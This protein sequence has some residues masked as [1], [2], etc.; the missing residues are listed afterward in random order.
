[1]LGPHLAHGQ[2]GNDDD[3]AASR[4]EG[5]PGTA[6]AAIVET[7]FDRA[8]AAAIDDELAAIRASSRG[9]SDSVFFIDIFG[10]LMPIPDRFVPFARSPGEFHSRSVF[11]DPVESLFSLSGSIGIGPIDAG[12]E[13]PVSPPD[14]FEP[15]SESTLSQYGLT[16]VVWEFER[17]SQVHIQDERE[18]IV[19]TDNNKQLWRAMLDAW[20]ELPR[21]P[22]AQQKRGER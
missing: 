7:N 14:G 12:S 9:E 6:I 4:T 19:I 13:S 16:V 20:N 17:F 10:G 11:G 15:C 5:E 21:D 2:C 1:M 18:F 3:N 8:R 22:V